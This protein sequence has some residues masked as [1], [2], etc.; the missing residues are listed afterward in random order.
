VKVENKSMTILVV[1][2]HPDDEVLGC[3]ASIAK[4]SEAGEL[5]HVLIMAEGVTSRADY[6]DL[7]SNKKELSGL[8]KS[9]H[10]AVEILG[11][12]S[13]K[14]LN[15]PDN[16]MDSFD[17]LDIIKAIEM[18]IARLQPDT[19]VTHHAGDVNIDHRIIHEAVVTAC[20]PQ[21]GQTVR[22]LLA[23]EV[24]SSTEWQ[25]PG[26]APTFQPN[27]FE[28]VTTSFEKKSIALSEYKSELRDW[29]HPRSLQG[30]EVLARWRGA[31]V[32]CE[33]AES[34]MLLRNFRGMDT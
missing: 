22:K 6:R 20:R 4:W 15:F 5:I 12:T 13:V 8:A 34:F 28:D 10:R 24:S 23:F 30:I 25:P 33:L 1:A 21:L 32:G 29:P 2:A 26:S 31:T 16:R 19:V 27:W 14:L 7:E 17:I 11:G 3:G 9:A 18:E